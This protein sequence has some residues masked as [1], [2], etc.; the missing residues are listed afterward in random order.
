MTRTARVEEAGRHIMVKN[1]DVPSSKAAS[2][3][4]FWGVRERSY[5]VA[6]PEGIPLSPGDVVEL[7]L[8][9]GRTILTAAFLFLLPLMLFP[10]GYLVTERLLERQA[11]A[12]A[13]TAEAV[14][15]ADVEGLSFLAGLV[16]LAAGLPLGALLRRLSGQ[17]GQGGV[18]VVLGVVSGPEA[19]SC[20]SKSTG[21]GSCTLCG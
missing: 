18:P 21:C 7:Y 17:G 16:C 13:E 11:A 9:P 5:R 15:A 2:S 1:N 20:A 19:L 8:P 3:R 6:N 12:A 14:K 4:R 10:A